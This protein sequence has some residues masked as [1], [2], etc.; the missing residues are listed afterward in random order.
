MKGKARV[1]DAFRQ[2]QWLNRHTGAATT[3]AA[4]TMA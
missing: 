1:N 3:R 4:L 2:A